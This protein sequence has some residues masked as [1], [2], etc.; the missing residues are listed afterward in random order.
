MAEPLRIHYPFAVNPEAG[1]IRQEPDYD[2]YIRQLILQI[3]FTA[4]GERLNRPN[5]GAGVKRLVFAPNS[6]GT[7]SLA[8]TSIYQGLTTWLGRYIQLHEVEA[9]AV[10]EKLVIRI[11]YTVLQT[12]EK[13]YLNL[14]TTL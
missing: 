13:R 8:R 10:G 7:A 14:E 2:A 5:F 1:R 3:L 9:D 11:E 4:P 6:E 12:R